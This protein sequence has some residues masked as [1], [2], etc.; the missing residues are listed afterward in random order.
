M[1]PLKNNKPNVMSSL[2]SFIAN[3]FMGGDANRQRGK[4]ADQQRKIVTDNQ[5]MGMRNVRVN[6]QYVGIP[7]VQPKMEQMSALKSQWKSQ[8]P[9]SDGVGVGQ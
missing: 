9:V 3:K 2:S 5:N 1:P 7:R 8:R 6:G 4:L